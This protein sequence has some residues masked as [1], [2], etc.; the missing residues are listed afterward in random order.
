MHASQLEAAVERFTSALSG[1]Q[2]ATE[3]MKATQPLD[4]KE[5]A[6]AVTRI[7]QAI[8]ALK[9]VLGEDAANGAGNG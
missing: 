3:R 2:T 4:E 9:K 5:R 7:D 1:L 8:S 6:L